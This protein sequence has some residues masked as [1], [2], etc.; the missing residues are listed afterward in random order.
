MRPPVSDMSTNA[1]T[2]YQNKRDALIKDFEKFRAEPYRDSEGIPTIGYGTTSYPDG[3]AV[4]MNDQPITEDVADTYFQHHVSEFNDHIS[5]SPGFTD[6]DQGTQAALTSF[7]YNTGPNVFT[8]PKGYETLQGAVQSG[9]KE[10]IAGAMRLYNN[11][12]NEGLNR[13]REAEIKLMNTPYM[14]Q[15]PYN[16]TDMSPNPYN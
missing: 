5:Q 12:G 7:A 15:T 11:G 8:S 16:R 4:T 3:R 1:Q 14:S 6:L 13:R 2:F 9:D 10:Q